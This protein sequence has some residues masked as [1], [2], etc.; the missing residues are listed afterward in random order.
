[1]SLGTITSEKKK[2]YICRNKICSLH[3][4]KLVKKYMYKIKQ[5][6]GC[7]FNQHPSFI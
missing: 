7:I 2:I 6:E 4:L 5:G 1:M 3:I